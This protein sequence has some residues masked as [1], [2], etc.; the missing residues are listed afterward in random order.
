MLPVFLYAYGVPLTTFFLRLFHAD[1]LHGLLLIVF[2][3]VEHLFGLTATL[4]LLLF[5]LFALLSLLFVLLLLVIVLVL[6]VLLVLVIVLVLLVLLILVIVLILLI[7]LVLLI[8]VIATTATLFRSE[9]LCGE[10]EV[11]FSLVIFGVESKR[12]PI[13]QDCRAELLAVVASSVA[14]C[15]G[16]A[17]VYV[18]GV[19]VCVGALFFCG[20]A[21]FAD[22]LVVVQG[23]VVL[24]KSGMGYGSVILSFGVAAVGFEGR[25]EA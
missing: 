16:F 21:V 10:R 3:G 5:I 1:S 6:L 9:Q 11:M 24:L 18:A 17:E 20:A 4:F 23:A 13:F 7:L 19:I 12:R 22:T 15:Q 14:D 2:H 8:L 25:A